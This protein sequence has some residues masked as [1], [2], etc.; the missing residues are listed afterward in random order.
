MMVRI[1]RDHIKN[2]FHAL[3]III[4][5]N[6]SALSQRYDS[7]LGLRVG[8]KSGITYQQR[9]S[10]RYT[11][12]TKLLT[13]LNEYTELAISGEYHGRVLWQKRLNWYAGGGFHMGNNKKDGFTLGPHILL[14]AEMTVD[15]YNFSVDYLFMNY[16]LESSDPYQHYFGLSLRYILK[17]RKRKRLN[18][19]FWQWG[20]KK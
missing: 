3:L 14:G 13:D 11:I 18:L 15:R 16:M 12:E 4:L 2:S 10:N 1:K 5:F 7:A 20:K 8:N 19:R 17:K 9:V 6:C